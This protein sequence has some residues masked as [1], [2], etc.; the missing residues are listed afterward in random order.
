MDSLTGKGF[1]GYYLFSKPL[2]NKELENLLKFNLSGY[3]PG[4]VKIWVYNADTLELINGLPFKSKREVCSYFNVTYTTL[5]RHLDTEL[6]TKKGGK[7]VYIFS[8]EISPEML[9][10]LKNSNKTARTNVTSE[11]FG[12]GV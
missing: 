4:G 2:T 7:L 1:N 8:K 10:K 5:V 6:A 11:I 9:D 3:T 12:G